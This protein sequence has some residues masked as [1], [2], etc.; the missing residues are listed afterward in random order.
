M[1]GSFTSCNDGKSSEY[2]IKVIQIHYMDL[3][4]CTSAAIQILPI[5][6]SFILP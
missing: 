1:H 2:F 6:Y 5:E 4:L 3:T